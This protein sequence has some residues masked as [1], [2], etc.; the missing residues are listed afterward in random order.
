MGLH[1]DNK[2]SEFVVSGSISVYPQPYFTF[3]GP[4]VA[5]IQ[6]PAEILPVPSLRASGA[7]TTVRRHC[8]RTANLAPHINIQTYLFPYIFFFFT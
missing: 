1:L 2:Q 5:L 6:A 8:D 7:R 3:T 4:L